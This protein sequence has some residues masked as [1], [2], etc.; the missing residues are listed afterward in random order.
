MVTRDTGGV[1]VPREQWERD[2]IVA[3]TAALVDGKAFFAAQ[4]IRVVDVR[5]SGEDPD[6]RL[7]VTISHEA[8]KYRRTWRLWGELSG[9]CQPVPHPKAVGSRVV[10][11]LI[12][13]PPEKKRSDGRTPMPIVGRY[14]QIT[15]S[16]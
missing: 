7:D 13:T 3:V 12:T 14:G 6:T 10:T 2:V 9:P 8:K 5:W 16:Y 4:G 1:T 15:H 11:D